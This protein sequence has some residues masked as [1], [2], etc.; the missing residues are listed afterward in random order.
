MLQY[1]LYVSVLSVQNRTKKKLLQ[2]ENI[3][4]VKNRVNDCEVLA[5]E[6]VPKQTYE[7][8]QWF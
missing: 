4:S 1:L 7:L 3:I 2:I 8:D 6:Q 5:S